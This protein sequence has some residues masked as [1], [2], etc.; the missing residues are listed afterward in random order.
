[1]VEPVQ[2]PA[3]T[4]AAQDATDQRV[5]H[6]TTTASRAEKFSKAMIAAALR[7][8]MISLAG[9]NGEPEDDNDPAP[10]P[11][12]APIITVKPGDSK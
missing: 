5:D 9:A 6:P 11:M 10:I 7:Q 12:R 2:R 1:M 4:Q 3:A 8:P